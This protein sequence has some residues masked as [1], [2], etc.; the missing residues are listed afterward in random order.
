MMIQKSTSMIKLN[1]PE[2][3]NKVKPNQGVNKIKDFSAQVTKIEVILGLVSQNLVLIKRGIH[4]HVY[5][6]I[7]IDDYYYS[8][9]YL[10]GSSIGIKLSEKRFD[11]SQQE[12]KTGHQVN[13]GTNIKVQNLR[14]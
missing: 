9:G 7:K 6:A 13:L 8:P 10:T 2:L 4:N 1:N 11:T 3:T 14:Y 12:M 5:V